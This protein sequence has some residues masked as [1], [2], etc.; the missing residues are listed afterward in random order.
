MRQ[1]AL[2]GAEVIQ[3]AKDFVIDRDRARLVVDV[4]LAVD[5]Q[6]L[7]TLARR[8]GWPR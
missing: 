7:D 8:A 3:Q 4:A 6:G 5:R 1:D 2:S